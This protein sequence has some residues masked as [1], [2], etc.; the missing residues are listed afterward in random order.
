MF[1][2]VIPGGLASFF[3]IQYIEERWWTEKPN[4]ELLWAYGAAAGILFLITVHV[5]LLQGIREHLE[6]IYNNNK[7]GAVN[8][9]IVGEKK[10]DAEGEE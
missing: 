10:P 1:W 6:N 3:I 7:Y 8:V 9:Y 2:H 5:Y 4:D